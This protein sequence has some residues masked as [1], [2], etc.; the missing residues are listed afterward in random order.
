MPIY[1]ATREI[2]IPAPVSEVHAV[3][4]DY[5]QLPEWM[6]RVKECKVLSRD[7]SGRGSEVEYAIDAILRTVRYRVRHLYRAEEWIGTEYLGG[8]FKHFGGEYRFQERDSAS[9]VCFSLAIDPGLRVPGRV[10][11]MLN[12]AVMASSLEDL[13]RR[14]RAVN[15]PAADPGVPVSESAPSL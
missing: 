6:F 3:L 4:T 12:E 8:D 10:A 2:D 13:S 15:R 14:V 9:H 11:R 1:S 5:E 7:E